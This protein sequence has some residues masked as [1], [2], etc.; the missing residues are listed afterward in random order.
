MKCEDFTSVKIK[1]KIVH[2]TGRRYI[3]EITYVQMYV[4][5]ADGDDEISFILFHI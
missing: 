2:F 3:Y 1:V 5:M 4:V